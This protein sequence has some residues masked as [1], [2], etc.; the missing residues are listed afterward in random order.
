MRPCDSP[1]HLI[2]FPPSQMLASPS[3][4]PPPSTFTVPSSSFLKLAGPGLV[5]AATG[6]GSGDVVSATVGGARYGVVTCNSSSRSE[7]PE[8]PSTRTGPTPGA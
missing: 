1:V 8:T 3:P 5:V 4:S 7:P 6:I 2:R